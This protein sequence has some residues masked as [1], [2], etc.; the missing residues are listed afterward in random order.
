VFKA[1]I[2]A[3]KFRMEH[4]GLPAKDFDPY[5]ESSGRVSKVLNRKRALSLRMIASNMQQD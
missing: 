3:I 2:E 5:I 1:S 4:Q